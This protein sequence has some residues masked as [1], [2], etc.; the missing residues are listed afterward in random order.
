MKFIT[1]F[2]RKELLITMDFNKQAD[3]REILSANKIPYVFKTTNLQSSQVI[4]SHRGRIGNFGINQ[5]Y[6]YEYKIYVHKNDYDKAWHLICNL[7]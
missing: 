2:N 7:T 3:V 6:S 1:I 4:G 5:D